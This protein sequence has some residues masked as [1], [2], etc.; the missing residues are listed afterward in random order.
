MRPI[1]A[2]LL[3]SCSLLGFC[4]EAAQLQY[5]VTW[6]V[7]DQSAK[8]RKSAEVAAFKEVLIR[9]SGTK[10]VLDAFYVRE[11]YKKTSSFVRTFQ[12][13]REVDKTTREVQ[14][15]IKFQFEQEA[16]TSLIN[17][18]GQP[19]WSG[20]LPV[21]LFWLAYEQEGQRQVLTSTTADDNPVKEMLQKQATRRGLPTILP[22]M[23]LEDSMQVGI[24][25]IWG[26][27]PQPVID[28]STRY[29]SEAIVAGR[30]IE[31]GQLWQ[32]RF[33]INLGGQSEYKDFESAEQE[34]L[35]AAMMDWVG[36][37]LCVKYCVKESAQNIR[38]SWRLM[39]TDIGSFEAFR[40]L[41]DYLQALP[42][43]RKAEVFEVNGRQVIISIDLVGEVAS[44]VQAMEIDNKLYPI[45]D[46]LPQTDPNLLIYQ[47]RP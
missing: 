11:S 9:A 14:L 45:D 12:Y 8:A 43:I 5:Q 2:F 23:D 30:V 7:P 46:G 47:W 32:G 31:S 4:A 18:A 19:M 17:D 36:E 27:F 3:L 40:G 35:L 13:L 21:S 34:Q 38:E 20:S 10:K 15:F 16:I 42:A 29:G 37:T 39:V 41:M 25:D 33:F 22:L 28:A 44:L 1:F 26:R 6:P 24:S